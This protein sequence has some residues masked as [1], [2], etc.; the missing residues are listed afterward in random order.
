[1][2]KRSTRGRPSRAKTPR[3]IVKPN[4]IAL[5]IDDDKA[6]RRLLRM[7][8]ES[9]HYRLLETRNG[10]LGLAA[11]GTRHL[12]VIILELALPDMGGLAVLKELR[13]SGR[14]PVL[15]LSGCDREADIVAALDA[16]ANDYMT[17]PFCA[18][19]LLARLRVLQRCVPGEPEAPVVSEGGLQVDLTRH[20]VTIGG[21]PLDL[22]P[23]EE[24][25]LHVLLVYAGKVVAARCLLRSVWGAE[26]THPAH[27]I[28]V[29]ISSLRKKLEGTHG[30]VAIE[31]TGSLGYRLLLPRGGAIPGEIEFP[32]QMIEHHDAKLPLT[33]F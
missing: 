12:D 22:S 8:L 16:G 18:R 14:T 31:T 23:T 3:Q 20:L 4:P 19:E 2:C 1:M 30:R 7:L 13:Q 25:L 10:R 24:A 9:Q 5:L 33:A 17:K 11:A 15:V 27:Y 26:E 6:N 28:R 29:F 21:C 32:D